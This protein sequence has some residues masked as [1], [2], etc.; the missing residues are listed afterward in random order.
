M[1]I[2]NKDW[3][4]FNCLDILT[5]RIPT[6]KSQRLKNLKQKLLCSNVRMFCW[7]VRGNT[8][9]NICFKTFAC[10]SALEIH[11]RSHTKERPFKCTICDRGFSTKVGYTKWWLGS[12]AGGGWLL[13]RGKR[14]L[15][16]YEILPASRTY[17]YQTKRST[18]PFL[19]F[20]TKFSEPSLSLF[21]LYWYWSSLCATN[22][23]H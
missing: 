4:I 9:C 11:Y 3:G 14:L 13:T 6:V 21:Y 2:K 19:L 18:E 8:T 20:P 17:S 16:L 15:L 1:L 23:S 10:H 7:T 12:I 22:G 5:W